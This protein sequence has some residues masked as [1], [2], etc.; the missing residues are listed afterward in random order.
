MVDMVED[1]TTKCVLDL[2]ANILDYPSA[3]IVSEVRE[4]QTLLS[5]RSP[6]AATLLSEFLA[7]AEDSPN[8]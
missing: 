7:L 6:E 1:A 8:M 5:E 2:F 4:C 3:D